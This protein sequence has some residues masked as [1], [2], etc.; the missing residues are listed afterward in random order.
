ME[1]SRAYPGAI[2]GG[3]RASW[4]NRT[5]QRAPCAIKKRPKT[6]RTLKGAPRTRKLFL[7]SL[8]SIRLPGFPSPHDTTRTLQD[9][10]RLSKAS[11][12]T[13]RPTRLPRLPRTPEVRSKTRLQAPLKHH[14]R[15]GPRPPSRY[16][17]R[18]PR[19]DPRRPQDAINTCC[20]YHTRPKDPPRRPMRSKDPDP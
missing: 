14:P 9:A 2:L 11:P 6:P 13:S 12:R 20:R 1:P 19:D 4:G 17:P 18:R 3:L 8:M 5:P 10:P 16:A 15:V 7:T